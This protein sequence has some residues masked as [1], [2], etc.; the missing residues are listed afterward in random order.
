M[1]QWPGS[2][3]PL[4]FDERDCAHRV[5]T[6]ARRLRIGDNASTDKGGTMRRAAIAT[7]MS[8]IAMPALA[9][10]D[11]VLRGMGSFHIGGRI[12]EVNGKPVREIVRQPGGPLT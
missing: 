8:L 10:E 7:L 6:V 2:S 1:P 3:R 5:P 12:A 9:D 4:H 11:I